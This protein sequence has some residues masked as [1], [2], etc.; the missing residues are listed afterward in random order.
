MRLADVI[1]RMCSEETDRATEKHIELGHTEG[2]CFTE[3]NWSV[4]RATQMFDTSFL[5]SSEHELFRE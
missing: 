5:W 3:L 2:K 1:H 4:V